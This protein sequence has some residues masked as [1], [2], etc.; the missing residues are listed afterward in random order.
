MTMV[1]K[2]EYVKENCPTDTCVGGSIF[3][4]AIKMFREKQCATVKC[5]IKWKVEL[6]L[7]K[8]MTSSCQESNVF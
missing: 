7:S 4:S 6:M 3:Y 1:L 5:M 2:P 8:F